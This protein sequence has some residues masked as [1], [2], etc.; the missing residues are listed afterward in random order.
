MSEGYIGPHWK[1]TAQWSISLNCD[2]PHCKEY[3]DLLDATDFWDGVEFEPGEHNT[4]KSRDVHVYCPKCGE[5]FI[6]DLEY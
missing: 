4:S 3:V 1:T 2:C 5:E 6:V